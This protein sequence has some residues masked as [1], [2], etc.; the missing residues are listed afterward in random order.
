[1][2]RHL[3]TE[4]PILD[5]A[6]MQE[7]VETVHQWLQIIG[8]IRLKA[9]PWLNHSWHCTLYISPAGYTTNAICFEGGTFDLAVTR[10]SGRPAPIHQGGVPN[11]P[12][13]VMQEAY[14]HEV[15]SAGFW[16]GSK[17]SPIPVYYAYAYPG[18]EAYAKK[19]YCPNKHFTA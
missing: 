8:K 17:D 7:T 16:P 1:M 10:F 2:S 12:L 3:S 13:D 19:R 18:N 15:S 4:W 14:S 11:M 9:M 6:T 5:F